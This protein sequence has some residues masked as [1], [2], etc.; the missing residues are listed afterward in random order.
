MLDNFYYEH[1]YDC[2]IYVQDSFGNWIWQNRLCCDNKLTSTQ[3]WLGTIKV[4]IWW[5]GVVPRDAYKIDAIISRSQW[6]DLTQGRW[7]SG[8]TD[9]VWWTST[10]LPGAVSF[11]RCA[12][13]EYS[14]LAVP[15]CFPKYWWKSFQIFSFSSSV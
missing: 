9:R 1:Y 4:W 5:W 7:D 3:R 10:A 6:L 13:H 2:L 15:S 12:V 8:G 14:V 11:L